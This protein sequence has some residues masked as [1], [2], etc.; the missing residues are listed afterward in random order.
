[1]QPRVALLALALCF[2]AA[3]GMR[4]GEAQRQDPKGAGQPEPTMQLACQECNK[5]APYLTDCTCFASDIMGTFE[6]DATK[7]LT[8]RKEFGTETV[9]TGAARLAEGWMWHCRPVSG[10]PDL[11]KPCP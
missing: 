11:W 3:S 2:G 4:R 7:T 6:N 9:N 1:M 8:T 5:H 10:T